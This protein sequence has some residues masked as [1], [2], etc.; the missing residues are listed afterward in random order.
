MSTDSIP[1]TVKVQG[2]KSPQPMP[3]QR[4]VGVV[5][6]IMH[7]G[8]RFALGAFLF[9]LFVIASYYVAILAWHNIHAAFFHDGAFGEDDVTLRLVSLM[10]TGALVTATYFTLKATHITYV[11]RSGVSLLTGKLR[12]LP[13]A[14]QNLTSGAVKVKMASSWITYSSIYLLVSFVKMN[15]QAQIDGETLTWQAFDMRIYVHFALIA[16]FLT[17]GLYEWVTH[18]DA[19]HA[20][21]PEPASAGTGEH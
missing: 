9:L 8:A 11:V 13:P 12:D 2:E 1:V 10:D 14:Y 18:K 6:E 4:A 15:S 21:T 17:I 3:L 19:K 5:D 20:P 7:N 16:G